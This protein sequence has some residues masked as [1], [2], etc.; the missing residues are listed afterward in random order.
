MEIKDLTLLVANPWVD[1]Y[2]EELKKRIPELKVISSHLLHEHDEEID[3]DVTEVDMILSFSPLVKSQPKMKHLRWFQSLAAGINHII[4]SGVLTRDVILTSAAGVAGIGLSEF[5]MAMML[6][7]AKKLPMMTNNQRDKKWDFWCSGELYG[8]TLGILGLGNLGKPIAKRAKLGFEMNV[9]AF[10]SVVGEY[11]HV[12]QIHRE[13]RSVLEMSDFVVIT[14]PLT[15]ETAGL[16]NEETLKWLKK[17]AFLCNVG[18]GELINRQA[19][20]K[21]L[22]E[23][24]I[25]GAGLDVFWGDA[26]QMHLSPDDELWDMENIIISPHVAWF[27]ENY[28]VRAVDLFVKNLMRFIKGDALL[29]VVKW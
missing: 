7:F 15:N 12:D 23:G 17:S 16:L 25:A 13:L 24:W 6:S 29:N 5:V 11:E 27:S 9:V 21:A 4:A 22:K 20:I 14:L 3:A 19:L 8:K 28:H 18:R 2:V 10:D 26:A 1:G